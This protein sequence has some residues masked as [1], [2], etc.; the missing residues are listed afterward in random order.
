LSS[1]KPATPEPSEI[2]GRYQIVQKLGAGAFGTVYKAKDKVLGRMVA[3]KTI[4]LEGLAAAGASLDE[5]LE[6][7]TREAQVSAQI[8]HPNIVTVY[9]IATA[10]GLTYLA[11]EFLDGVGLD[12][13]ISG[14]KLPLE[15]AASIG[16]QVADALGFAHKNNI[17]HRDIKPANIMIEAGDR[18]KVTD[19]GIAKVIN[20]GEHLTMTGSL[21]GT[22]SYMSPEQARGGEIDGRS[23]LFSV[24]CVLYE[25]LAGQKAFRGES[26]TALIF[27]IITEEPPPIHALDPSIPEEMIRVLS[28]ALS[29]APETRYQ[30]G[31]ELAADLLTFTRPGTS[32]TVRVSESPTA[33]SSPN[34]TTDLPTIH[35]PPTVAG[36]APTQLSKPTAPK[37]AT[38]PP[39]PPRAASP[40]P[41]APPP[42][43]AASPRPAPPK[44][45]NAGLFIVLGLLFI[46][47]AGGAAVA[48]WYF[49]L[50]KPTGRTVVDASP[51]PSAP[52][53]TPTAV[54]PPSPEALD[55]TPT[56][57]PT[58]QPTVHPAPTQGP[59]RVAD[60]SPVTRPP[61]RTS[62][63]GTPNVQPP[64]NEGG[65]RTAAPGDDHF[66]EEEAPPVNNAE[67]GR[68][69]AESYRSG[70][71]SGGSVGGGARFNPRE[72]SPRN[73]VPAERP[74]VAALRHVMNA[75]EVYKRK[76]GRYGSL[77]DMSR[78]Q[79][80]LMDVPLQ[81]RSFA[82]RGYRFELELESDG[83]RLTATPTNPGPRP[84][85]GDDSGFIREVD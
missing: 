62:D 49:F 85:L 4:R 63:G 44:R 31:H 1:Q 46:V 56:S 13:I 55:T 25:M 17:V 10:D 40:T 71:S 42:I 61:V 14:G 21:L 27:K 37:P 39:P 83:Y 11:M 23:D 28:K 29:K 8:K 68:R 48:G 69:L 67:A 33:R 57:T 47:F 50:R 36:A 24:G 66:L 19:F 79:A 6:R 45:S 84:F 32:P 51:V 70:S 34:V 30:T 20:S 80:L 53:V 58:L 35:T 26:I 54:A 9:D 43:P 16:A 74:A 60:A 73:L 81:D 12:K 82:R 41:Q 5:L 65:G 7:F 3:I 52:P 59:T 22:P 2:A 15:R 72:R 78:S 75:E 64:P 38:P 77:T 18:V 76:T